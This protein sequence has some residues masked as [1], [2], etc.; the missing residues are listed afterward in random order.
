MFLL[1]CGSG[2]PDCDDE[3]MLPF[4]QTRVLHHYFPDSSRTDLKVH[5]ELVK[6]SSIELTGM[7]DEGPL[8]NDWTCFCEAEFD[9]KRKWGTIRYTIRSKEGSISLRSATVYPK[10][11]TR[12][13]WNW[14]HSE[15]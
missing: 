8:S 3:I 5:N 12:E 9:Y 6:L 15:D 11:L 7:D 4:V 2:P 10:P 14:L 1:A 13:K